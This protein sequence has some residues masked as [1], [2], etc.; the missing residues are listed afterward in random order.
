M[1]TRDRS[2]QIDA[3]ILCTELQPAVDFLIGLGMRVDTISPAEDPSEIV[4]CAGD[5]AV[6]VRRADGAT[7]GR[8]VVRSD[9]HDLGEHSGPNGLVVEVVPATP[10]V[11]VPE[12]QPSLT[13]V[14]GDEGESGVGR[15]GML[16]R[17]LLPDRWGGRFIASHITIADGGEVPDY[18]HFHRIRFQMIFVA[19]GWVDVVYEDQGEPFR[20]EAGDCV[21]QPPEIR[22]RVLRSSP[23]LEVIEIGC[24]ALHE[25][26]AEPV[27]E[28]PTANVDTRRDFGGQRFV[29][30]IAAATGTTSSPNAGFSRRDTGI[31]EATDGLAGANV[32]SATDVAAAPSLVGHDGEF[33]MAV[34]LSGSAELDVVDG[35]GPVTMKSRSAATFPSG[36]RWSWHSVSDDF[37]FLE[38]SLPDGAVRLSERGAVDQT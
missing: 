20:M 24:P 31:G 35:D 33:S 5:G 2:L 14:A 18:V 22:H 1:P 32:H 13:I 19:A 11:M 7:G 27:I 17:D 8:L 10:R 36:S 38:I 25:T 16:Y 26:I 37:S 30:H 28:L 6:R 12:A 21:L 4:L 9:V 34:V 15:A 23:G 29:R 3:L